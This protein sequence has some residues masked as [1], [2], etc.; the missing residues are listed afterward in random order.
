MFQWEA[1]WISGERFNINCLCWSLLLLILEK[2]R[3]ILCL[4]CVISEAIVTAVSY[5]KEVRKK[6]WKILVL[7]LVRELCILNEHVHGF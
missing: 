3:E 1:V 7:A 4:I 5:E 6:S 2:L